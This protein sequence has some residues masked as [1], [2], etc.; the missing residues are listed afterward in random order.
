MHDEDELKLLLGGK[1]EE[2]E[3]GIQALIEQF[4]RP[5]WSFVL[6]KFPGLRHEDVGEI[7]NDAFEAVVYSIPIVWVP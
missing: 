1:P 3:A 7:V 4:S 2:Q 5:L 6:E